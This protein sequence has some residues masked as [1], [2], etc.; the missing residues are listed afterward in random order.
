MDK[1]YI[2][3]STEKTGFQS[4]AKN[5]F[6]S[7]DAATQEFLK[8][9]FF[10]RQDAKLIKNAKFLKFSWRLGAFLAH[11]AVKILTSRKA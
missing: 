10:H 7:L 9:R 5:F 8:V 11:L 6:W 4:F 2:N 1:L 3:Y